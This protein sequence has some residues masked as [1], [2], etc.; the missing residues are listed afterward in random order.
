MLFIGRDVR[1]SL[2]CVVEIRVWMEEEEAGLEYENQIAEGK[3]MDEHF[4]FD[5][6]MV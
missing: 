4:R 3:M 2:C 6:L 5:G 1:A